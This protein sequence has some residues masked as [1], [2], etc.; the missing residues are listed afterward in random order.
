MSAVVAD[1]AFRPID[2]RALIGGRWR[3]PARTTEIRDPYR[4]ELVGLA[5][6]STP[7][8]VEAAVAAA[9]EA[10]AQ[11]AAFDGAHT[12]VAC[13]IAVSALGSTL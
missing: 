8:E 1:S 5:P 12:G 4:G 9:V 7:A 2:A 11:A 3:E 13:T 10:R 6:V